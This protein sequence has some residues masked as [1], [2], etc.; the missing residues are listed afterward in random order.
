MSSQ[1]I[2][3]A[4]S[5]LILPSGGSPLGECE[6]HNPE[7]PSDLFLCP[8]GLQSLKP[9][10]VSPRIS[11]TYAQAVKSSNISATTQRKISQIKF[12]PL[13]LL[14]PLSSLS[15]TDVS[16]ST[17]A[18]FTSST[19]AQLL[20]FTSSI[21]VT[22]QEPQPPIPMS[23]AVLST[24]NNMFSSIESSLIIYAS[25]TNSGIQQPSAFAIVRN[26]KQNSK[27]RTRKRKKLLKM[28]E[29]KTDIKMAP[30]RP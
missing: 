9:Q 28:N 20:P 13:N 4:D 29:A 27:T 26:S 30:H 11:Q 6:C 21:A 1:N 8:R 24:T 22:V 2:N 18:I 3:F 7:V 19:Q 10:N 15:K 5:D 25:L 12:P 16:L 14:Q 17:P 23:G